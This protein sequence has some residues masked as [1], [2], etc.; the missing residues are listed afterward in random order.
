MGTIHL[1]KLKSKGQFNLKKTDTR[2]KVT[3]TCRDDQKT[4]TK[5]LVVTYATRRLEIH[6][7]I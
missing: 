1:Q 6:V 3:D 7:H 5:R 4:D 2:L